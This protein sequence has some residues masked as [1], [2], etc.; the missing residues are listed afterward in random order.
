MN[1]AP[2]PTPDPIDAVQGLL[3]DA[4]VLARRLREVLAQLTGEPVELDEL[5]RRTAVTRRTV[6]DLLA[7]AGPDLETTGTA[8]RLA[9]QARDRYRERFALDELGAAAPT[10]P[11]QAAL[12]REFIDGGPKPAAALD[13]VTATPETALRR[14]EWLRDNYDLRGANVLCLGD[15][16]LTSLAL[17]LVAPSVSVTVVDVDER[18]LQHIDTVSAERG[19][20]VRTLHADLRFGVPPVLEGWADLVFTDPPYTPEGIGLFATRAAECLAGPHSRLLVAY[21]YSPRTPAL[22]HKVQQE[23]LRLG[24]VFEAILPRFH[25]YFGAQAIGSASDLYVCQPTAHTRKLALRQAPG[26]YTHGP[27]SV[28]AI[29]ATAPPEFLAAIGERLGTPVSSLRDPGWSRPIKRQP[30]PPVYDL[31][32][33]PGPWLLR[34]LLAGNTDRLAFLVDNNHPDITSERAQH[35]L[36]DLV[37]AK[38]RLRFHRS[39]PNSRHALVVADLV[40]PDSVAGYLL[41]RAHGKIGNVCRE[42]LIAHV[43]PELTK[44]TAKD[45]VVALAPT[46]SDL[47]LRLI[48]LPRHRIADLLARL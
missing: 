18:I 6:E 41:Q 44:R 19:F 28:E 46:P 26:I 47:D 2:H 30:Q 31:R 48:D 39:T 42:G 33:D 7:A 45:R 14:A 8:H 43:D 40:E 21:G 15:H 4:G 29:E 16:D 35:A 3:A 5:I 36:S 25:R 13:H 9:P 22:G 12:M 17:G 32:S 38:Y 27:Q 10:G 24:M 37:A 34:M 11:E 23:L 20:D 1:T